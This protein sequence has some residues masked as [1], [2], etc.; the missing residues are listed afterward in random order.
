MNK[1]SLI[2]ACA[3]LLAS[4]STSQPSPLEISGTTADIY[5]YGFYEGSTRAQV[6]A[7]TEIDGN[8]VTNAFG[9]SRM[10]SHG[11]RGRLTT[12]FPQ[13]NVPIRPM[14]V[15]LH[16]SHVTGEAREGYEM[17]AA[18]TFFFVEGIVDF[19]PKLNGSYAVKGELKANKSSVWIEDLKTG[20]P[21]T[22]VVTK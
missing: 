22:A 17:R 5:D 8:A 16:A 3:A 19:S 15:K 7:L 11:Q 21:V 2:F 14:K 9:A 6:F 13:R 12:S 18:G 1:R 4:C 10:A 20:L